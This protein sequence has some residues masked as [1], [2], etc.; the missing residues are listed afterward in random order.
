MWRSKQLICWCGSVRRMDAVS[1][2]RHLPMALPADVQDH[3]QPRM[4][5]GPAVRQRSGSIPTMPWSL[6]QPHQEGDAA[7]DEAANR[8]CPLHPSTIRP[9]LEAR[10]H[11]IRDFGPGCW[12]RVFRER[13]I[14]VAY[15]PKVDL[16]SGRI[17]G[18]ETLI[19]W[20]PQRG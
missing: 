15:Q 14:G 18:A 11:R 5:L 3:H 17:V 7:A 8:G 20:R 4:A 2:E 13:S 9:Y 19:R 1:L 6:G 10:N 16:A 12:K